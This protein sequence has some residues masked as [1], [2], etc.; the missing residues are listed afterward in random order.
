[1]KKQTYLDPHCFLN[2]FASSLR[3]RTSREL[4]LSYFRCCLDIS[5]QRSLKKR[6]D[7]DPHYYLS[8]FSSSLPR[9]TSRG[10]K[11]NS[12]IYK[13]IGYKTIKPTDLTFQYCALVWRYS[14]D[15]VKSK[16]LTN[17]K[18]YFIQISVLTQSS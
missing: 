15:P 9:R 14:D 5:D 12:F 16:I 6:S 4:K 1:M 17:L 11:L 8:L 18:N 3:R 10:L 7:L 13:P 2:L